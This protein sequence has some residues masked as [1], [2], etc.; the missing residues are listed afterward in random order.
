MNNN[1][2]DYSPAQHINHLIPDNSFTLNTRSKTILG[3]RLNKE[4]NKHGLYKFCVVLHDKCTKLPGEKWGRK[5]NKPSVT[6]VVNICLLQNIFLTPLLG[7][8]FDLHFCNNFSLWI[9]KQ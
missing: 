8:I 2:L 7:P 3:V 5:S 6:Q 9:Q 4:K 1:S